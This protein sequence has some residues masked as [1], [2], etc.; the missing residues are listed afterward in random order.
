MNYRI[1]LHAQPTG[2]FIAL[3]FSS[4]VSHDYPVWQCYSPLELDDAYDLAHKGLRAIIIHNEEKQ[5]MSNANVNHN[6]ESRPCP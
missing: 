2:K 1:E 6:K 4:E 3:I 5:T